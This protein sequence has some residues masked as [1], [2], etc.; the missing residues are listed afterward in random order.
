MYSIPI[1]NA[2]REAGLEEA[3]KANAS[4]AYVVPVQKL[5]SDNK[6]EL[7]PLKTAA[8]LGA[9]T[10]A[11]EH[12]FDL[13]YTVS[14]LVSTAWNKN[15]DVFDSIEVWTARHTPEHKPTNIE[16]NE[17]EI[18]GHIVGNW[19]VN[20][21]YSSIPEDKPADELP[22]FYH[23]VTSSVIY[24]NWQDSTLK[25]RAEELI[26]Q[27][28]EGTKFVSM[29][30]IF[31]GFDY[32]VISPDG[33][34]HVIARSKESAFLTKH[35]RSYGG[36][37]E[38]DGYRVGRLLRNITFCGKGFVDKPANPNSII[39]SKPDMINFNKA[40][41][42]SLNPFKPENGVSNITMNKITSSQESKNMSDVNDV[43]LEELKANLQ[44]ALADNESLRTQLS[45]ADIQK[46]EDQVAD[47]TTKIEALEK[48]LAQSNQTLASV[49]DELKQA[50]ESKAKLQKEIEDAKAN[51]LQTKRVYTLVEGG[52]SKEEAEAKVAIFATL[53]DEQFA[54]IADTLI[55]KC[56]SDKEKEEMKK[57][58]KAKCDPAE[59]DKEKK[60]KDAKASDPE[61]DD[62]DD[63]DDA[64]AQEDKEI[65]ETA[66]EDSQPDLTAANDSTEEK[67]EL[68][69]VRA[70]LLD[71]VNKKV[72]RKDCK[73]Q[74]K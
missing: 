4:I 22:D 60:K 67:D 1:F 49:T 57:K 59:E 62:E 34:N 69:V 53:N 28:E 39:F 70:G 68:E 66:Q 45:K 38:Y 43:Y 5:D 32:A 2:E 8:F 3:I 14:V 10:K 61:E 27:I 18:V 33:S 72:M 48:D 54:V 21:D 6:P 23:L 51:E 7:L 73:S 74:E 16:H 30:C 29:E 47:L 56:G 35:L 24:R 40:T 15:D 41:I 46:F 42:V 11:G 36:T 9:V 58:G 12:D 52:L 65:L 26:Q 37:G 44:K 25:A 50:N 55:A 64:Q 31:K 13:Y 17:K 20:D 71:F 19:P 63:D